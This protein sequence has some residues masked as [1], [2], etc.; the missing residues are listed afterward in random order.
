MK[1]VVSQPF[2]DFQVGDSITEP[3]KIAEVLDSHSGSV[4]KVADDPKPEDQAVVNVV[5]VQ[6]S[7]AFAALTAANANAN[8]KAPRR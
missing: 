7:G 4:V 6:P 2:A 8:A 3:E 1:L 5:D